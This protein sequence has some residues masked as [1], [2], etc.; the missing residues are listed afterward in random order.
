M[1]PPR[2]YADIA[3]RGS[4]LDS[5]EAEALLAALPPRVRALLIDQYLH[6]PLPS[7]REI[8]DFLVDASP[9]CRLIDQATGSALAFEYL[10]SRDVSTAVDRYLITCRAGAQIYERLRSLEAHLPFWFDRLLAGQ[11]TIRIDNVGC[12]T[13]R[14]TIGVLAA[15]RDLARLATVRHIDPDDQAL[16]IS[17]KLAQHRGVARSISFHASKFSH[18][19]AV[20]ADIVLLIGILCPL[21]RRVSKAV[22]R[23]AA[24]YVRP[25]GLVIYSTALHQMVI[26]DPLTDF[27]MRLTG[28]SM[29]YKS[30]QETEELA[31]ALGW[32]IR[33][34][35]FDEPRHHHCM[36][37][38]EVPES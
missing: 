11:K 28:W 25:G 26:D 1:H 27:L 3:N 35:F 12:G 7:S 37:V 5:P 29:T 17:R 21:H 36:V 20:G 18:M 13:G 8:R 31:T 22:L 2:T 16:R 32:Q 4:S 19:P 10:Y 34:R 9:I 38:A 15:R 6:S 24:P 14:D 23:S 33:G 30:E